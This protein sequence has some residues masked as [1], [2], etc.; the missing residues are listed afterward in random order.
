MRNVLSWLVIG[1]VIIGALLLRVSFVNGGAVNYTP[2]RL[3]FPGG[4]FSVG[5]WFALSTGGWFAL[6]VVTPASD[7]ERAL[8]NRERPPV[9]CNL[10]LTLT[11]PNGLRIQR[12]IDRLRICGWTRETT[13]YSP[14]EQLWLPEGG[15]YTISL[16]NNGSGIFS[17]RGA[18][19]QLT[20]FESPGHELL[21]PILAWMAYALFAVAVGTTIFMSYAGQTR[22][23][24][25]V[26]QSANTDTKSSDAVDKF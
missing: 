26:S 3:P 23:A 11:G 16:F 18:L 9:S 14:L 5:D 21:F 15:Q 7:V 10:R 12:S 4:G 22:A 2:T 24:P 8:L 19:V 17:D 13:I 20:R 25:S 6:E 1:A